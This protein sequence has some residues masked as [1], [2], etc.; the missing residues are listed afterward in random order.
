MS[1]T[2]RMSD[3][4][5]YAPCD[6]AAVFC[7]QRDIKKN[8]AKMNKIFEKSTQSIFI[9]YT[10]QIM[11]NNHKSS[12]VFFCTFFL[13]MLKLSI[14]NNLSMYILHNFLFPLLCKYF[15]LSPF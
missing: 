8:E 1:R 4:S 3:G 12:I 9:L 10:S 13:N 14:A 2:N 11:L 15:L 5:R 6:C 7:S